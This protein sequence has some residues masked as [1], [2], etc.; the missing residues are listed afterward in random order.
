MSNSETL[1]MDLD[2]KTARTSHTQ[3]VY[4]HSHM[5]TCKRFTHNWQFFLLVS[6]TCTQLV[7]NP[8]TQPPPSSYKGM[9]CQ[10]S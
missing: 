5:H 6:Y 8:Q 2:K 3:T 7:L 9:K 4:R 1:L 10:L